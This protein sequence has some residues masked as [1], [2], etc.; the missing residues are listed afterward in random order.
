M[1][2]LACWSDTSDW[3]PHLVPGLCAVG[4]G[5]ES[6]QVVEGEDPWGLP[7]LPRA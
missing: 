7:G 1:G 6:R 5:L 4:L 2:M 3:P